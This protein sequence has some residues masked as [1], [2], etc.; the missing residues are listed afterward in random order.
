MKMLHIMA[1]TLVSLFPSSTSA[2]ESCDSNILFEETANGARFLQI[3]YCGDA[4]TTAAF[5]CSKGS[6]KVTVVLP[7]AE[8]DGK[9]GANL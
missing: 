3:L 9:P 5:T 1:V 6:K 8:Y 7:L 4:D 2:Q